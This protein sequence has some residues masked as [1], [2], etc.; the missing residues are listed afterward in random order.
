MSNVMSHH[1]SGAANSVLIAHNLSKTY[2]QGPNAVE[3]LKGIHLEV[4][5][6]EKVAIVGS[7]GSG[8][9]TLLHLLGGLDTPTAGSV[10]LSGLVLSQL[11]TK[12]LDLLRN[13]NL[14]FIYQ[15]HH[16]LDE[17]TALENVA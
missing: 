12:Q 14:G 7:S 5:P 13:E 6:A 4:E 16:L 2:G 3:V 17:F 9:S 11:G 8:K 10:T 1:N 15:F